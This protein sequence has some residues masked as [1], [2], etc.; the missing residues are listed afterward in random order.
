MILNYP[1][2]FGLDW[3]ILYWAAILLI[4]AFFAIGVLGD[5]EQQQKL[6]QRRTV[7]VGAWMWALATFLGGVTVA[8]IY[9]LIHH[10]TLRPSEATQS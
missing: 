6:R 9:W 1:N 7:F 8:G 2:F 4:H 10:S 3:I 5:A